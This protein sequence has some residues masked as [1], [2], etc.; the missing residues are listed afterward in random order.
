[1]VIPVVFLYGVV[2]VGAFGGEW[3]AAAAETTS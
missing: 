1:M 2:G 3:T